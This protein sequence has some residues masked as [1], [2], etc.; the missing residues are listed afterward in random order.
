M[1]SRTVRSIF[2]IAGFGSLL[3]SC[4]GNDDSVPTADEL[5]A[6]LMAPDDIAGEWS[7]FTGPQGG[8]EQIDPSGILTEEQR[9]LVPSFDLCDEAGDEALAAA[10]SLRPVVF[11]QMDLTTEDDIDPPFDRSGHLI[12]SQQFLYS[13]DPDEMRRAFE[14]VRSGMI[15]CLGEMPAGE[16]GPGFSEEIAVPQVGDDRFGVLMTIEEAGGWAEWHIREVLLRDGP[17]L[18][19]F[20]IV[21]IRADTDPYFSNE[22]FGEMLRT[23]AE[24]L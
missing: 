13:G 22:D 6:M 3:V 20:V 5:S 2:L 4:G 11:R 14:V 23:A 8:D 18:M 16:E 7:V 1:T 24:K 12:F 9:E 10:E 21:D 15:A 19:K 17:I